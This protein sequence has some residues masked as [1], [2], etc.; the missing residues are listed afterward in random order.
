H[1]TYDSFGKVTSESNSSFGDRYK[2]TARELDSE[3]GLQYNRARYYTQTA[4]RWISTDPIGYNAGDANLY[5]Y[6]LNLPTSLED[7]SGLGWWDRRV[8]GFKLGYWLGSYTG[9]GVSTGIAGAIYGYQ[10]PVAPA[11][12]PAAP[13]ARSSLQ[14]KVDWDPHNSG[15]NLN[16]AFYYKYAVHIILKTTPNQG[17]GT[18]IIHEF[19]QTPHKPDEERWI[20]YQ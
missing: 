13:I 15:K 9:N 6:V 19:I 17:Q 8:Q 3:T 5:R 1:I 16:G 7:P 12:A 18:V 20:A 14:L 4:G 10:P 11:P 2:W